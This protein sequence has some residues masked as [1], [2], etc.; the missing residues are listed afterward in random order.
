MQFMIHILII[1][2]NDD[3]EES[4]WQGM[5]TRTAVDAQVDRTVSRAL[6]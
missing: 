6:G 4:A 3:T 2:M 1:L 5:A